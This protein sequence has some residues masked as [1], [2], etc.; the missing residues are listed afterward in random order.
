MLGFDLI[1]WIGWIGLGGLDWVDWIGWIGLDG[2]D[3]DWI[4]LDW[5]WGRLDGGRLA[6]RIC[7]TVG[8]VCGVGR[9]GEEDDGDDDDDEFDR[10]RMN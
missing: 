5:G 6:H 1:G 2:L 3:L 8:F 4:G 7:S 9:G 10:M